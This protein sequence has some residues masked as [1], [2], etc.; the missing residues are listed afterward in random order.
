MFFLI[1][2]MVTGELIA[3]GHGCNQE[4]M[5]EKHQLFQRELFSDQEIF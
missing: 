4:K 3:P 2:K 5:E 1:R